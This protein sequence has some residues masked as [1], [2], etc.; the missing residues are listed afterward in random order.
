MA[1]DPLEVAFG[2]FRAGQMDAAAQA[3]KAL[4]MDDPGNAEAQ[5]MIGV[6][7][8]QQGKN[9]IARDFMKRATQCTGAT[10]EMFN[11][12]GSVLLSL[13][14]K[15]QAGEA[16]EQAIAMKPDYADALN[17]LGIVHRNARRI[18]KAI[19]YLR[20]AVELNPNHSHAKANL[21]AAYRDVVPSWHFAMMDDKQRNDAY[22]AA[23]RRAVPGKRVLDIGSGAG[24]LTL[25]SARAGAASVTGCEV[26]SIIAERAD[27][28]VQKN[29]FSARAKVLAK[30]SQQ[31][32]IGRDMA[33]RA[34]VLVTETFSSGLINE[35]VL[36]TLEHA[37]E[38]LLTP[39]AVVIPAVASIMGYLVG[40]ETLKGV[41]FVDKV[42]GFDLS[43]FDDFAPPNM[44]L[45]L[46]RFPHEVMSGDVELM[47]F[48]L[49]DHNF[50]MDTKKLTVPVTRTGECLGVAQWIR[51][52]LDATTRYE[53]RPGPNA[54]YNGHWVHLTYRFPKPIPLRAGEAVPLVVRHYRTQ[55]TVEHADYVTL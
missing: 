50:P 22:E 17:N 44:Q 35:E 48:N 10:P 47:R 16:F 29:G 5:H 46:D 9:E 8:F 32:M 21:R 33:E 26:V 36:P 41:L 13:D 31:I 15:E 54:P 40:G 12:L 53:N 19:E 23:I 37:H 6:I 52:E 3:Y 14:E 39:D 11:N 43:P 42:S 55:I 1:I 18:E 51:L 45:S 4:L 49:K 25:M 7:A 30:P 28:I 34:Q 38:F 24:L 27:Q 2:H 20:R